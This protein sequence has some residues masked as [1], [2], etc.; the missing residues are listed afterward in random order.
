M[1]RSS[2]RP[3]WSFRNLNFPTVTKN[4]RKGYALEVRREEGHRGQTMDRPLSRDMCGQ[5]LVRS[6]ARTGRKPA[7]KGRRWSKSVLGGNDY[8]EDLC[9][10]A[11]AARSSGC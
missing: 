8:E 3:S 1:S 9:A 4:S 2:T 10:L 11:F 5:F 6:G 7:T